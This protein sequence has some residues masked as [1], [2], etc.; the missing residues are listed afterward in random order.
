MQITENTYLTGDT[1]LCLLRRRYVQRMNKGSK[2][3][4]QNLPES[5]FSI[6]Y[7]FLNKILNKNQITYNNAIFGASQDLNIFHSTM[8]WLFV[9]RFPPIYLQLPTT[10]FL[11]FSFHIWVLFEWHEVITIIASC[12]FFNCVSCVS[13]CMRIR[14]YTRENNHQPQNTHNSTQ[15]YYF[16]Y[17][18]KKCKGK[19][20]MTLTLITN[21]H[22][23][24]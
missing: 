9:L 19:N 7:F 16:S 4:E 13:T 23:I 21:M 20:I 12:C 10:H 15:K 18:K 11:L 14:W 5:F 17:I 24:I 22:T 6:P 1:H 2:G 3:S 8:P